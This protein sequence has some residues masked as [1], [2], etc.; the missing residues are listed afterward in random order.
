MNIIAQYDPSVDNAP[1]GYKTAVQAAINFVDHLIADPITVT[2]KFSYGS[3]QGT[4]LPS[5]ALGESSTNGNVETYSS[6]VSLLTG[7][8]SSTAD[9]QSIAALPATD[10]TNGG[11]FWVSDALAKVFGLGSEPGYTDP[12]DGFVALSS[13]YAFTYDP[14]DRSVSGKYDAIG[15]LEHEITEAIG[16]IDYQGGA[17]TYSGKTLYAPMDLF[18]Y[19][20][21]GQHVVGQVGGYFSVDGQHMLLP[22]ND[23]TNGGDGGDW[24]DS[25]AGDA[26]GDGYLGLAGLISPTDVQLM[27][28]LGFKITYPGRTDFHNDGLA[29]LL[30]ENS[31]GAVEIGEVSG[32]KV[33]FEHLG[34]LGSEWKFVGTGDFLGDGVSDFLIQNTSGA[35]NVGEV[36]PDLTATFTHIASLGP[37]WT[38][39]GAGDLLGNGRADMLIEN[40]NGLVEAAEVQF[41]GKASYTKIGTLGAEW[42]FHGTGDF[43]GDGHEQFLIQNTS[44]LVEV[45]NVVNSQAQYTAV[46]A[47][48]P[49]WKFVGT[50]DF[51]GDGKTG[52]LI[53]NTNGLVEVGEVGA[54]SK[55]S[56]TAVAALGSEWKFV[57]AGDY[58]GLGHAQFLIENSHGLVEVGSISG[59]KASYTAVTSVGSEWTFHI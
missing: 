34:S 52:F 56:Y 29:N 41:G 10:P 17:G 44:G 5:N 3:L 42:S 58:L 25:V 9:H 14:N 28:V 37:E 27:D 43:L 11:G 23:P 15:V 20:G 38:V 19:S 18:H 1:A 31:S 8:A 16:R 51:L 22:F 53:E 50:G 7:A 6:L 21:A 13:K 45:G 57:G 24:A 30:M 35:I 54:N 32:Q 4:A 39:V 55:V 40:T 49:E 47:L 33:A 46:A 12:E 2:I 59:G 26:F 48:G 36:G